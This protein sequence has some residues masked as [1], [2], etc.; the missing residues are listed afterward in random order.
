M[1]K[2][3]SANK[4]SSYVKT[5]F[6][7]YTAFL[8][9]LVLALALTVVYAVDH[10]N[11]LYLLL[12]NGKLGEFLIGA[13]IA[14]VCFIAVYFFFGIGKKDVYFGDVL[15]FAGISA[16]IVYAIYLACT[17]FTL[18]RL[19]PLFTVLPVCLILLIVRLCVYTGEESESCSNC[20]V[21]NLLKGIFDKF[22]FLLPIFLAFSLTAVIYYL[23]RH[24]YIRK[25]L[26]FVKVDV[27]VIALAVIL[28][29]CGI[30]YVISSMFKNHATLL[31]LL[32]LTGIYLGIF[33]IIY[34]GISDFH[35]KRTLIPAVL[36]IVC[37]CI[38][39][40]R[41]KYF[42]EEDHSVEKAKEELKKHHTLKA[43]LILI[44]RY[45]EPLLAVV[46]AFAI[47][48]G[49]EFVID[50]NLFGILPYKSIAVQFAFYGM[51]VALAIFALLAIVYAIVKFKNVKDGNVDLIL[52]TCVATGIA[53]T[54]C[55]AIN[56][57]WL[58]ILIALALTFI[59]IMVLIMRVKEVVA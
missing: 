49:V 28:L 54:I 27:K 19:T 52:L 41:T 51:T 23:D 46:F 26:D 59:F 39:I 25:L 48:V 37:L 32:A 43:Y 2:V 14:I 17:A 44:S 11:Y 40:A 7:K 18:I 24:G 29:A 56:L 45:T 6:S 38:L 35:L 42:G 20:K 47:A 30:V 16:C 22:T 34:A 15:L 55:F 5:L 9:F 36:L 57:A 4:F 33:L 50:F 13:I 53:L 3:T 10:Y 58:L 31:D 1:T 8:P 12:S 21:K